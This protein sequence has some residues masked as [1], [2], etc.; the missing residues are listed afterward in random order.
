MFGV[1]RATI[2]HALRLLERD[3]LVETRRG[4]RGGTFV[5]RPPT[6]RGDGGADPAH[7]PQRDEIEQLLVYRST[8]EPGVAALAAATRSGDDLAAM[9]RELLGWPLRR[10]S[11]TCAPTR[12][13][14]SPWRARPATLLIRAIEDIRARLSDA[15]SLLPRRTPGTAGSPTSTTRSG[16]VELA[17]EEAAAR[18]MAQHIAASNQGIRAILD[19]IHRRRARAGL[20]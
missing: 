17:D 16:A 14:I 2:Q 6:T 9:R 15:I 11:T 4:R 19:A 12:R 10:S 7:P 20:V 3:R 18:A 5:S 1:G 8:L 13:S